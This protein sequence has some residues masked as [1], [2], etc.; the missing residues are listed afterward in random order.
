MASCIV[1]GIWTDAILSRDWNLAYVGRLLD[2]IA[3]SFQN[4]VR[5][6]AHRAS[7]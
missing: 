4:L 2:G 3:A 5:Y 1:F 6:T 7:E